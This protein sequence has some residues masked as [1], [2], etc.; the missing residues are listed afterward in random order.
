MPRRDISQDDNVGVGCVALFDAPSS[1][2]ASGA[3]EK[4]RTLH[5]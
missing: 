5:A 4:K 1:L 2:L 3:F